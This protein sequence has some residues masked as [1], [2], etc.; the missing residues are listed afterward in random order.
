MAR[1]L[2]LKCTFDKKE[3]TL[4]ARREGSRTAEE[5]KLDAAANE[6]AILGDS[7][8]ENKEDGKIEDKRSSR[9][10]T[11]NKKP[12]RLEAPAWN[13]P[14]IDKGISK[15]RKTNGSTLFSLTR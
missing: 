12:G 15:P 10:R 4:P 2:V 3:N 8:R 13:R 5:T 11:R 14:R 1:S 9:H 6:R 7:S